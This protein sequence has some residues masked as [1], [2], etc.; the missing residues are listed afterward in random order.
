[1][2]QKTRKRLPFTLFLLGFWGILSSQSIELMPGTERV[3]VDA[4]FL[5]FLDSNHS[6]SLF[7]RSRATST[8]DSAD[9]NLF[10]GTYLN[11]TTTS[12]IGATVLGRISSN[13]SGVDMGIHYFRSTGSIMIYTLASIN[14]SDDLLYSWFTIFRLSHPIKLNWKLFTG[15]ELF[16]AFDKSGHL[17][18]VQ[19]VRFGFGKNSFQFGFGLNLNERRHSGLDLNPGIFIRNEF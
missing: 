13:G 9:S 15:I 11:Y 14:V 2:I 7:S 8:Y 3:F 12:G 17:S 1:M 19:R 6:F 10:S 18:S 5:K 4:Q 16:S